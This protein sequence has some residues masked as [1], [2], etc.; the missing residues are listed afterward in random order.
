M[1]P[2][3]TQARPLALMS[4]AAPQDETLLIPWENHLHPLQQA[5]VISIW[6]T[7]HLTAGADRAQEQRQHLE[8]AD[9]VVLFLSAS[10]FAEPTC[11][12]QMEAAL[13]LV[14]TSALRVI[15]L[16]LRS[17]IWQESPLGSFIPW[18]KN[19]KPIVLWEDQDE[20]WYA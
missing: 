7:L 17:V 19:G 8:Q 1:M 14:H 9:I 18:P 4:V 2:Q 15:P 10:F 16:L 5:K 11:L 6:S 13:S 20:G 12:A 3:H